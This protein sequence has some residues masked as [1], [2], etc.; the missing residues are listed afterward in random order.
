MNL[1]AANATESSA[2]REIK[3]L[4]VVG[5]GSPLG[6]M[7]KPGAFGIHA[8]IHDPTVTSGARRCK[9]VNKGED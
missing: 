8:E 3:N 6:V 7:A 5:D 4:K 9:T 2:K 1:N